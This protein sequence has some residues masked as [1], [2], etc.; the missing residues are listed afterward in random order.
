VGVCDVHAA[1]GDT[2]PV[3]ALQ[4][5]GDGLSHVGGSDGWRRLSGQRPAG[6]AG[7]CHIRARAARVLAGGLAARCRSAGVPVDELVRRRT[8]PRAVF[9]CGARGS[10]AG[11]GRSAAE[12]FAARGLQAADRACATPHS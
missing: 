8:F 9:A 10:I 6:P 5:H 4:V 1:V 11:P 12:S 7:R 2:A 3:A